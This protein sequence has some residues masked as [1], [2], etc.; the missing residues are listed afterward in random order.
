MTTQTKASAAGTIGGAMLEE[1]ERELV[2]TRRFLECPP[3][4]RP[5]WRPHEKSMSAGQLAYHI[6]VVPAGVLER[7]LR[8][9]AP[10]RR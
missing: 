7:V 8:E 6:A 4:G 1:F 10:Q 2:T 3:G 9:R 5:T